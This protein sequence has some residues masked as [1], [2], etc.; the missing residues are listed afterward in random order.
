MPSMSKD[1]LDKASDAIKHTVDD[2]KDAVHE[3]GHRATADAEK[4]KRETLGDEMTP[5][6]KAG[7]AMNEAKNRAQAEYDSAKRHLRDK[8]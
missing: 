6:E 5:S 1:T 8:T 3:G 7:S 4:S 2:V